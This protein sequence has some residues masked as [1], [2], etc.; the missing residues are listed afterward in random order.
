MCGIYVEHVSFRF[1]HNI[2]FY[3]YFHPVH[4]MSALKSPVILLCVTYVCGKVTYRISNTTISVYWRQTNRIYLNKNL[5]KMRLPLLA[6]ITRGTE[7]EVLTV[8]LNIVSI[9]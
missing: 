9:K 1:F 8:Q 4:K 7:M 5:W 2:F 6:Q 3:P